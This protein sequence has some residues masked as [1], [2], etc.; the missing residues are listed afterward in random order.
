MSYKYS[1]IK[2]KPVGFWLLN[3]SSGTTALDASGCGNDGEYLSAPTLSPLPLVYGGLKSINI[4]SSQSITFPIS[5]NYVGIEQEYPIANKYNSD[6]DFSLEC[7]V[8]PKSLST[9]QVPLI[10][11]FSNEIGL[12]INDNGVTFA[13]GDLLDLTKRIDY[14][15]LNMNRVLHIVCVYSPQYAAIY[16]D[17][18]RVAEKT[19]SNFSFNNTTL[20]LMCGPATSTDELLIDSASIYRYALSESQILAHYSSAQSIL[21]FQ[22]TYPDLG[23]S[24]EIYDNNI[25]TKFSYAYPANKAWNFLIKAGLEYNSDYDYLGLIAGSGDSQSISVDEFLFIPSQYGIDDSKIE[26]V[27]TNGVSVYASVDGE[28][29][30]E[31]INGEAIPQYRLGDFDTSYGLYLRITFT[32]ADDSLYIPKLS[33]LIVKFYKSQLMYA[34]N[35][36]SYISQNVDDNLYPAR[37][38]LGE[39]KYP[40]LSRNRL[41]GVRSKE[42]SGFLLNMTKPTSTIEFFYTPESLSESGLIYKSESVAA[43]YTWSSSGS[44]TKTNIAA[45]Y[46]NGLDKTSQTNISNVFTSKELHHVVVVLTSEIDNNI[47]LNYSLSGSNESVYQYISLYD[48]QFDQAKVSSHYNLFVNGSPLE[49]TEPSFSITENSVTPLDYDWLV[50]QNI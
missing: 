17:G 5:K 29:Y 31:C 43:G 12:F 7:F 45:I 41:N 18:E 37:A 8:F 47:K 6:N 24:F 39:T 38:Y 40:I 35:T 25:S 36:T 30:I 1:I 49:S 27:G 22:V 26:W 34:T 10:A 21:P 19:L 33:S 9:S 32:T 28:T 14:S 23:E 3:E 4:T 20:S 2:D 50:V 44:I 42:D 46:V 11:D 16:I 13:L 48:Y 15:I